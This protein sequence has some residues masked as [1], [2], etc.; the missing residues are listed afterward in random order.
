MVIIEIQFF[1]D[2][3]NSKMLKNVS[4]DILKL[5]YLTASQMIILKLIA[6]QEITVQIA[7]TLSVSTKTIEKHRSNNKAKLWSKKEPMSL[8]L[9]AFSNKSLVLTIGVT[10]H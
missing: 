1:R 4:D 8:I 3:F 5:D 6:Q 9:W 10:A 2:Q 7:A